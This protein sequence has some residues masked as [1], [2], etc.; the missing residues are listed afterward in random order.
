M[1]TISHIFVVLVGVVVL[2]GCDRSVS[3]PLPYDTALAHISAAISKPESGAFSE[4]NNHKLVNIVTPSRH[5]EFTMSR[6]WTRSSRKRYEKMTDKATVQLTP[7]GDTATVIQ[8]SVRSY[9][10]FG[11]IGKGETNRSGE[12]QLARQLAALLTVDETVEQ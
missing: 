9:N 10:A 8:I 5:G 1:K 7:D 4:W 2:C 12:K 3:I 11:L 6:G